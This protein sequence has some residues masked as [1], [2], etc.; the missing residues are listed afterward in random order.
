MTHINRFRIIVDLVTFYVKKP[1]F[2][3]DE[4]SLHGQ[5]SVRV[6]DKAVAVYF[7]MGWSS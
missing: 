3:T 1:L 4:R 6:G 7:E 5:S 2:S